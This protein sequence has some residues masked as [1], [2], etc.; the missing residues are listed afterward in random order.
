MKV[1]LNVDVHLKPNEGNVIPTENEKLNCVI[2][3]FNRVFSIF[4]Q[5]PLTSDH[6][7][8]STQIS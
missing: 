1:K 7:C 4:F 2:S 5:F 6:M 8:K 3:Q